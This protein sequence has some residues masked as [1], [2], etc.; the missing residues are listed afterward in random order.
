MFV[1]QEGRRKWGS[2]FVMTAAASAV[3]ALRPE[4]EE[5]ILAYASA[6]QLLT[7]FLGTYTMVFLAIPLQ[8]FMYNTLTRGD[9]YD[10]GK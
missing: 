6:S 3:A 4:S 10:H 9:N 5:I 1:R 8:R 2:A 7:S